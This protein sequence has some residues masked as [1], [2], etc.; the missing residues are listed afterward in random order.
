MLFQL[1]S[2]VQVNYCLYDFILDTNLILLFHLK[3]HF[4]VKIHLFI[5]LIEIL[6]KIISQKIII[7]SFYNDTMIQ[8]I[9]KT[10]IVWNLMDMYNPTNSWQFNF[11]VSQTV[12][13]IVWPQDE[14]KV[15]FYSTIFVIHSFNLLKWKKNKV[16]YVSSINLFENM[17]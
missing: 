10:I 13:I 7:L 17:S 2:R 6:L 9:S 11:D 4:V 5:K 12:V 16:L 15:S 14:K 3:N 1:I 8:F